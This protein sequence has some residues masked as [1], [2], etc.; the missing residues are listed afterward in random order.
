[1]SEKEFVF[2]ITT[3]TQG[4]KFKVCQEIFSKAF[5]TG[6]Y[7][8]N[9]KAMN[10][11][12]RNTAETMMAD[13]ELLRE[14]FEDYYVSA[15]NHPV[16][17]D[18]KE[19]FNA[20]RNVKRNIPLTFQM[21]IDNPKELIIHR[22]VS[23]T[24]I[25]VQNVQSIRYTPPQ[26]YDDPI[27]LKSTVYQQMCKDLNANKN[28]IVLEVREDGKLWATNTNGI[29]KNN[30]VLGI[31]RG[32][33]RDY[34]QTFNGAFLNHLCKLPT[35]SQQTQIYIHPDLPLRIGG[36][37]ASLGTCN[38]YIMDQNMIE[39]KNK[40]ANGEIDEQENSEEED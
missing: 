34:R 29:S 22:D 25:K 39:R 35:F 28:K 21:R 20:M 27:V 3:T 11:S 4:H 6:R 19:A 1:M 23:S 38:F 40:I 33:H 5:D 24:E 16:V 14:R 31:Y 7:E 18:M 17:I 10:I 2:K 26:E 30:A 13:V 37:V 8:F 9:S 12:L 32:K 36:T 15:G